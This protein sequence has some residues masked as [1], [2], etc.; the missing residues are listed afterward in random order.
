VLGGAAAAASTPTYRPF[1]LLPS[2]LAQHP[3]ITL[4]ISLTDIKL[5]LEQRAE[6]AIRVGR[7]RPSQ[8]T[9]R[10]LGESPMRV[11]PGAPSRSRAPHR[12][13]FLNFAQ[14]RMQ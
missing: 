5:L 9:S 11:G 2:F 10:K 7:L 6:L 4:D 1:P 3:E 12:R 8:F 13:A 14:H